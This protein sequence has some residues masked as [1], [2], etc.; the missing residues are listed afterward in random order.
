MTGRQV[1][2]LLHIH[3]STLIP[4][5][6]SGALEAL[7]LPRGGWRYPRDQRLILDALAAAGGLR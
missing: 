2:D 6:Q 1:C 7:P 5:R 3:R 4:W